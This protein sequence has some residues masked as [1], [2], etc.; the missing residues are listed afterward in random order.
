VPAR[1]GVGHG[2]IVRSNRWPNCSYYTN[3][4][5]TDDKITWNVE[6]PESGNFQVTLYYTCPEQD[7]GS[8]FQ[9][10]FNESSIEGKISVAHDPPLVGMDEDRVV[11]HNSYVK[12]FKPMELPVMHLE[13]GAGELTLQA[14][15]VPG[16]EVMDFRLLMFER[17]KI[18]TQ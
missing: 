15:D 18:S 2:N 14:L 9:L 16:S 7:I 5:S 13:K 12:D 1:D 11:R 4:I 3:W 17:I 8:T 6:V 10:S